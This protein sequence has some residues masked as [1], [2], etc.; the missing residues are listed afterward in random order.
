MYAAK[1]SSGDVI[2]VLAQAGAHVN[3][4]DL[5][6]ETPLQIAA[7]QGG[8]STVS[9][10]LARGAEVNRR[11]G[12]DRRT[13]LDRAVERN[14]RGIAGL[15]VERGACVPQAALDQATKRKD[16]KMLATLAGASCK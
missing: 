9:A 10:L 2:D 15:L 3:A 5:N 7:R 14:D 11:G 6:H 13:A 1:G 16:E 12:S 8:E 4:E